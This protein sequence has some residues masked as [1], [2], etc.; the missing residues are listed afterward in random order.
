MIKLYEILKNNPYNVA[1]ALNTAQ[2]W[3]RK[4]TQT[5][6]IAWIQGKT[7]IEREQ[8]Q[9]IINYLSNYK[10]EEQPFKRPEFWAA[11]C[12][13]SPVYVSSNVATANT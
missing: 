6:I 12:A 1:L 11:F 4:A 13:I 10:P 3:L 9:K 2:Q 7:E 8:K 5:Q